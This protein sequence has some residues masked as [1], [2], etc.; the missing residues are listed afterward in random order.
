MLSR[1]LR[2]AGIVAKLAD[3]SAKKLSKCQCCLVPLGIAS[4]SIGMSF[5]I[6]LFL[7]GFDLQHV[8]FDLA[9]VTS[10]IVTHINLHA[11][12]RRL[13]VLRDLFR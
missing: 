6:G 5:F 8:S 1:F 13:R 2:I 10:G 3:A 4:A 11:A 9:V 7:C 12:Y